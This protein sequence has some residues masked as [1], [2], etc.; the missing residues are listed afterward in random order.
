ML[1]VFISFPFERKMNTAIGN[2]TKSTILLIKISP[3]INKPR[4][5]NKKNPAIKNSKTQINLW[6][7]IFNHIAESVNTFPFVNYLLFYRDKFMVVKSYIPYFQTR[8]S[9]LKKLVDAPSVDVVQ[10][11]RLTTPSPPLCESYKH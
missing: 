6:N 1:S 9:R 11:K 8:K 3:I 7:L 2:I 5:A 4:L 10:Q